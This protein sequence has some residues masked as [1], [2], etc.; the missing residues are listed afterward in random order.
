MIPPVAAPRE[1]AAALAAVNHAVLFSDFDGTLSSIESHPGAASLFDGAPAVIRRL[2]AAV[3]MT[4]SSG[5]DLDDLVARIGD[6]LPV[7]IIAGHG[8]TVRQRDGATIDLIDIASVREALDE[9][10]SELQALVDEMEGW[11]IERK[12]TSVAAHY[13]C[14]DKSLTATILP[15]VRATMQRHA[16][17]APG[18]NILDGK[19]VI[20]LRPRTT[21]KGRALTHLM[22]QFPGRLPIAIGDDVTDEDAFAAACD[23]GGISIIV[24]TATHPTAARWRLDGPAAVI[25][26][27]EALADHWAPTTATQPSSAIGSRV[28]TTDAE[29]R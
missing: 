5:R 4:I 9:V 3:P 29:R 27:L 7:V 25:E 2:A 24:G 26:M 1:V 18:F 22:R 19:Q 17:R 15:E 12:P 28:P 13:R 11:L 6:D 23:A 8:S 16:T 10:A 20:E 14:A 21:D